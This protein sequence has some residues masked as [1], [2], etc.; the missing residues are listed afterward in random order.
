MPFFIG[1]V[2]AEVFMT[3][4]RDCGVKW[5]IVWCAAIL[6]LYGIHALGTLW[7]NDMVKQ[8]SKKQ[9]I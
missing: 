1:H 6:M 2:V 9:N 5:D 4:I 8:E 7:F 3:L